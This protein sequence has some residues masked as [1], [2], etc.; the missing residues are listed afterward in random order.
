MALDARLDQLNLPKI[1]QVGTNVPV[2]GTIK[3]NG[4]NTLTS[5]YVNW[6]ANGGTVNTDT[7]SLNLVHQ[8]QLL[9][10]IQ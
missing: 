10:Y 2:S 7:V 6:S 9:L 8:I 4:T 3:N 5:I 1:A